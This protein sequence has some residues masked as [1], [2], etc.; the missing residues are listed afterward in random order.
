ML[1]MA[2][3]HQGQSKVEGGV[4]RGRA[5]ASFWKSGFSADGTQ[6]I[7]KCPVLWDIVNLAAVSALGKLC[8]RV[9]QCSLVLKPIG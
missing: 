8:S 9:E 1:G 7:L 6:N 2:C 5:P 4:S 3:T